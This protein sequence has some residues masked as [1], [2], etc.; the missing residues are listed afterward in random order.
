M[1]YSGKNYR[2]DL[3]IKGLLIKT[4]SKFF[5]VIGYHQPDLNTNKDS[6][7]SDLSSVFVSFLQAVQSV[8]DFSI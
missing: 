4:I 8:V 7:R 5:K 2:F 6:V 3:G 1:V